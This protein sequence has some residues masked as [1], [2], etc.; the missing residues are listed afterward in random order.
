MLVAAH[1]STS[2]RLQLHS[3]NLKSDA[4]SRVAKGRPKQ[5]A[6]T[7]AWGGTSEP[8][9]SKGANITSVLPLELDMMIL[10]LCENNQIDFPWAQQ[11]DQ[12]GMQRTEL[13]QGLHSKIGVYAEEYLAAKI[14]GH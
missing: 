9:L 2:G 7:I 3:V 10:G 11:A 1:G 8:L 12:T 6:S 13:L 5:L 14:A 4:A